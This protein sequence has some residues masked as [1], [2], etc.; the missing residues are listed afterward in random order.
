MFWL[1]Y[2]CYI[3]I[4]NIICIVL[5]I[6]QSIHTSTFILIPLETLWK[7]KTVACNPLSETREWITVQRSSKICPQSHESQQ[8]EHTLFSRGKS[9][10]FEQ[11]RSNNV[12]CVWYFSV[13]FYC[14]SSTVVSI[15]S[16]T[17]PPA[18]HPRSYP[19][20]LCP[21][22]LHTCSLTA[23]PLFPPIIPLPSGYCQFVLYINVSGFSSWAYL[24]ESS[25]DYP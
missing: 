12:L 5:Y 2:P 19:L 17:I 3:N 4:H 15:F 22:V 23:L 24:K 20:W 1:T 7:S 10:D 11:S 13:F 9:L 25:V 8:I 21:C 18:Y 6:S 16:S 14:C